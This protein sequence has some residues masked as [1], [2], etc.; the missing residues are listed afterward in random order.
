MNI[1]ALIESQEMN[2]FGYMIRLYHTTTYLSF[3]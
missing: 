3:N 2:Q 1:P